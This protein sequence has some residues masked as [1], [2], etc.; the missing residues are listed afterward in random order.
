MERGYLMSYP[1]KKNQ[2]IG[3]KS[4]DFG[5][6]PHFIDSMRILKP[7]WE[8]NEGKY[9]RVDGIKGCWRQANILP[10]SLE[11]GIN[12]NFGR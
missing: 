6:K 11:C 12:N 4:F 2:N 10:V 7:I 5:G 8:D 1:Q 3:Y 9:S